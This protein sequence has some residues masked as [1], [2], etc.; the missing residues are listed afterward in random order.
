MTIRHDVCSETCLKLRR[1]TAIVQFKIAERNL[2]DGYKICRVEM[3]LDE[4]K[5]LKEELIRCGENL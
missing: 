2:K 3:S 1:T 4:L 5:K